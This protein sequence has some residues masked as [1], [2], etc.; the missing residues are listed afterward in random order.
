MLPC[1]SSMKPPMAFGWYKN[2]ND[3]DMATIVAYLRSLKPLPFGG[4]PTA[5]PQPDLRNADVSCPSGIVAAF[6]RLRAVLCNE[7]DSS[8]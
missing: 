4:A 2:I 5:K 8:A 3:Q 7:N 1:G 6:D